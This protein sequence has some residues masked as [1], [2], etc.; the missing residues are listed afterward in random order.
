MRARQAGRAAQELRGVERDSVRVAP[1][2][3][4][5]SL[6]LEPGLQSLETAAGG[7]RQQL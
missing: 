5:L 7:L 1:K 4:A 6:V 2:L 3:P